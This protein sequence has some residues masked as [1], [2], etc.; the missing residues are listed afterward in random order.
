MKRFGLSYSDNSELISSMDT[1]TKLRIQIDLVNAINKSVAIYMERGG[2][3][4]GVISILKAMSKDYKN[5]I[6]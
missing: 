1:E 4:L 2:S 3:T 6:K 5:N